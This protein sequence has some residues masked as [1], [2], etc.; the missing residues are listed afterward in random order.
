MGKKNKTRDKMKK[1]VAWDRPIYLYLQ[2][3]ADDD[4]DDNSVSCL[5]FVIEDG[6][7]PR[8]ISGCEEIDDDDDNKVIFRRLDLPEF[9]DDYLRLPLSVVVLD[10]R[11]FM[12]SGYQCRKRDC[13]GVKSYIGYDYLDLKPSYEGKEWRSEQGVSFPSHE[14]LACCKDGLIYTLGQECCHRLDP[15]SGVCSEFP[16]TCGFRTQLGISNKYIYTYSLGIY[17]L[18]FRY[19]LEKNEWDCISSRFW[20]LWGPGVVISDDS[21]LLCF[22]TMKPTDKFSEQLGVYVFD[23]R[24][25]QWLDE[26]VEGLDDALPVIP[27]TYESWER[28]LYLNDLP[29]LFQIGTKRF[30]FVWEERF[31]RGQGLLHCHKFTIDHIPCS[32]S[33]S[34]SHRTNNQPTSFVARIVSSGSLPL[35]RAGLLGCAV[36]IESYSRGKGTVDHLHLRS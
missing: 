11:L 12:I 31:V 10:S 26:P 14:S 30:A 1:T 16:A 6:R 8:Q 2:V 19:D 20:G 3:K 15:R 13:S 22:G 4:S 32:S 27:D 21:Y 18:L 34:S 35:Q 24:Q 23:I 29:R 5:W 33:S 9:D 28:H 25:R 36:G 17:N 7:R